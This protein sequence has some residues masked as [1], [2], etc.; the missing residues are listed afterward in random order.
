MNLKEQINAAVEANRPLRVIYRGGS[1]PGSERTITPISIDGDRIRARC[2]VTG[3]A[4]VFKLDKLEVVEGS[5]AAPAFASQP[6]PPEFSTLKEFADWYR[7]TLEGLGWVVQFEPGNDDACLALHEHFKNGKLR[8]TPT[9]TLMY[10]RYADD[11]YF[12]G[13]DWGIPHQPRER[14]RPFR[15]YADQDRATSY[16]KLERAAAVFMEAARKMAPNRK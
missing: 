13:A 3:V 1:Q 8:K 10:T 11:G 2:H 6:Q 14:T 16:G 4:K 12:E 7:D 15:V 5:G 9:A